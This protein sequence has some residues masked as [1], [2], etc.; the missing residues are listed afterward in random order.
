MVLQLDGMPALRP[1]K[2]RAMEK[3]NDWWGDGGILGVD[4]ENARHRFKSSS[5]VIDPE[6]AAIVQQ[7]LAHDVLNIPGFLSLSHARA[8]ASRCQD[9]AL[10]LSLSYFHP[11]VHPLD[12]RPLWDPTLPLPFSVM[13]YSCEYQWRNQYTDEPMLARPLHPR[14][15]ARWYELQ[16]P[17]EERTSGD[18]TNGDLIFLR[19]IRRMTGALCI[20]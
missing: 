18:L 4:I 2:E 11:L 19:R 16:P 7:K 5:D 12:P 13:H 8:L 15:Y 10:A 9:S 17:E 1:R 20:L 6:S 14:A 3:L